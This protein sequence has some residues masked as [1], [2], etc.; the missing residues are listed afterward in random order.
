MLLAAHAQGLGSCL[1]GAFDEERLKDMLSIP[2]EARPQAV[3]TIGYEDGKTKAP[4][5]FT[6]EE[7]MFFRAFGGQIHRIKDVDGTMG[8]TSHHVRKAIDKGKKWEESDIVRNRI[9]EMGYKVEDKNG[10]QRVSKI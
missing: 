1:I 7:V 9:R 5:K 2:A 8:F 4:P 3:I 10:E 6:L